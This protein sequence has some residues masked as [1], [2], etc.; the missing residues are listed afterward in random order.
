VRAS[1][2]IVVGEGGIG[3]MAGLALGARP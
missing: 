3:P 1:A 2:S